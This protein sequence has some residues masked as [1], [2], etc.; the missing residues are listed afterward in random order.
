MTK[1]RTPSRKHV[2]NLAAAA[3]LLAGGFV[4]SLFVD[5]THFLRQDGFSQKAVRSAGVVTHDGRTWVAYAEAPVSVTVLT[6]STCVACNDVKMLAWLR[7]VMPTITARRV[8][9]AS[10]EGARLAATYGIATLPAYLFVDDTVTRTPF[11]AQAQDLFDR[12]D[13]GWVLRLGTM[14]MLPGRVVAVPRREAAAVQ[15]PADA[16][17]TVTAFL[18]LAD[19]LSAAAH[20]AASAAADALPAAYQVVAV[21][22]PDDDARQKAAFAGAVCAGR[23]DRLTS[24]MTALLGTQRQWRSMRADVI[25]VTY[26]ARA[27]VRDMAAFRQCLTEAVDS[28]AEAAAEASRFGVTAAPAV[29]TG[30]MFLDGSDTPITQDAVRAAAT[31]GR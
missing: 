4:G 2:Q 10:E 30:E 22:I 18:D 29:V 5:V 1:E 7:Y 8:E 17:V 16:R 27:G 25:G 15:G 6:D 28:A 24:Y 21:A 20:R 19:P 9:I 26:A 13:G 31:A 12:R 11:Y 14:G 3:I 23:Q